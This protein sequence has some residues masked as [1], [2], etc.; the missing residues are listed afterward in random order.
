[1]PLRDRGWIAGDHR[2][3]G[4]RINRNHLVLETGDLGIDAGL[5]ARRVADALAHAGAEHRAHDPVDPIIA[6]G[7]GDDALTQIGAE[8]GIVD[9]HLPHLAGDDDDILF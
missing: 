1:M 2:L 4:S 6:T 5:A 7:T 9:L 3:D 8:G